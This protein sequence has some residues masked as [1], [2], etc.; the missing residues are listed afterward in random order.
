MKNK[1]SIVIPVYNESDNIEKCLNNL[2]ILRQQSVQVIIVDGG[3]DDNTLSK[4]SSLSDIAIQSDKSRATQM[5]KGAAMATGDYILFLHVDTVLP[6]NVI[7]K[8]N[9][10][11]I[12]KV[13][14]GRFD[15]KL[16][17]N[18]FLFRV[19]EKCMNIR[20]R[21]TGIATGDQVIF[22][23]KEIFQQVNGYPG[24]ELMEDIAISK[25]LLKI[26]KPVCLKE[27]VISSSRRWEK[28]G[29][30]KTILHMWILRLLYFFDFDTKKLARMYS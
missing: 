12:N 1:L 13:C 24:I 7:E 22:V 4:A 10:F 8:F 5:N 20:S 23:Y 29:I 26:S 2:Q 19:I 6:D 9:N 30:I 3:S 21:L 18:Q 11:D 27:K 17:G 14:W 15:I 25:T 28:N 16:S